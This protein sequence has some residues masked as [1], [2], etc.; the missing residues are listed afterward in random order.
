MHFI[1]VFY[2]TFISIPLLT[3]LPI[4]VLTIFYRVARIA[5][6]DLCLILYPVNCGRWI[7][8]GFALHNRCMTDFDDTCAGTLSY[9]RKAGWRFITYK[10]KK[11]EQEKNE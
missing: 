2:S 10:S 8:N 7:T 1:T 6:V 5:H 3:Q 11:K 9:Y 4:L